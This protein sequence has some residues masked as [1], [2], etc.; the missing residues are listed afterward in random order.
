MK[1]SILPIL[2]LALT[3][4]VSH[5]ATLVTSGQT[6]SGTTHSVN[7]S[8]GTVGGQATKSTSGT[9]LILTVNNP[10]SPNDWFVQWNSIN[11]S[12][13]TYTYAQVDFAAAPGASAGNFGIFWTDTDSTIGGPP[14]NS[15]T[16]LGSV[17]PSTTNP[18]SVVIDLTD[19]GTNTSGAK[20]WGPGNF[21]SFRIDPFE[22]DTGNDGVAFTI[23]GVTFGSALIPEPSSGVLLGLGGLAL[24]ATRRRRK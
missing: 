11:Q 8:T 23:T 3:A 6:V 1:I 9:D 19:G 24:I 12:T 17:T 5:A 20:G 7:P 2:F 22:T 21:G 18:F 10:T 13:A 16:Q 15:F 4:T 14:T